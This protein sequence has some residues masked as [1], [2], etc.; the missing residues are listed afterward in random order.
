MFTYAMSM[1]FGWL[2]G[3]LANWAA[4]VLPYRGKETAGR[5]RAPDRHHSVRV[6]VRFFFDRVMP[7]ALWLWFAYT[8]YSEM[9]EALTEG[10][11]WLLIGRT[12]TNTVFMLL[13]VLLFMLRHSP[14]S[15]R[16]RPLESV[17]AIAGTFAL[18]FIANRSPI[19]ES[20]AILATGT[21]I[22]LLGLLWSMVS[23]AALGRC[24][25]VFPEARGLVTH[26]TYRL[27]RHPLYFG[28]IVI[29]F[30]ILLPVF[31]LLSVGFWIIFVGLQLRRSVNEERVLA[32]T[33]P[34]YSNYQQR[35]RRLIPF[36]W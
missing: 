28:E 21:A 18:V 29:G 10:A 27:V 16:A 34:E 30:G 3:G 4:D 17:V 23:L 24:F 19:Y 5:L 36:M 12:V 11:H 2:T 25:G 7:A 26:G 15:R 1:L 13:I 35:T 14:R 32:A 8:S 9:R 20:S 6:A 22:G 31:S 33:F